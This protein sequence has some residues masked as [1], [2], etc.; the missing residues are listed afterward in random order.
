[1]AGFVIENVRSG[2]VKQ[3]HWHD[4]ES[5]QKEGNGVFLDVRTDQEFALANI[6]GAIHIP[7]DELRDHI[8]ELDLSKP[9][10]VNCHSGLRSYIACRILSENGFTC[11]NLSGGYRFYDYV[12]KEK[13]Y[14]EVPEHPCGVK[15]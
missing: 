10:Y 4:V 13:K 2:V 7:L 1:M 11:Y 15:I 12:L 8:G 6:T 9:L 14:D 3:Y 5:L